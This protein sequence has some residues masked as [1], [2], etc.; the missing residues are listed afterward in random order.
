MKTNFETLELNTIQIQLNNYCASTLAKNKIKHLS[1][2]KD[3]E[4]LEN[5]LLK[6]KDTMRCI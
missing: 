2:Y 5:E 3:K 1:I 6:V 4:K